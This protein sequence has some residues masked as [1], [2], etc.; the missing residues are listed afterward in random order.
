MRRRWICADDNDDV[1]MLHRVEVLCAGRRSKGLRQA[2]T[3]R[4]VAHAGAG[5]DIVI[6][7]AGTDQLLNQIGFFVGAARG[8]DAADGILAILVLNSFE[9]RRRIVDRL[10]P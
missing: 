4:R 9:F 1:G 3:G 2:I 8:R 6:T 5:V 10:V 7:E